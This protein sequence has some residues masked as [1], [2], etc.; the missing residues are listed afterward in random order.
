VI[1]IDTNVLVRLLMRDD[2]AQYE[3]S[4]RLFASESI[5]I[6]DTVV[7]ET[8]WV[9]RYAYEF[10]AVE[11]CEALR[12]VFGLRNVTLGNAPLLAQ[13]LAWHE[14]GLDF[15][16]ALHLALSHGMTALKTFDGDFV[17]RAS[18]LS[19]CRVEKLS[20]G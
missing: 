5:F 3:A 18:N 12:R 9:L 19:N 4:R 10:Q 6:P 1:A 14:S 7:L 15:A 2:E 16:D 11:I 20:S 13:A 17:K 8:E